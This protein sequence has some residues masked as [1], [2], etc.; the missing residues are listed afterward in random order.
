M[1][2]APAGDRT[3][4]IAL[5]TNH[6]PSRPKIL[7]TGDSIQHD[8]RGAMVWLSEDGVI[9]DGAGL[10]MVI[11]NCP[12]LTVTATQKIIIF[13]GRLYVALWV[14][15]RR[16]RKAQELPALATGCARSRVVAGAPSAPP[17]MAR[18]LGELPNL[19]ADASSVRAEHRRAG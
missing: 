11:R 1:L 7:K 14:N 4:T 10:P 2:A 16:A 3:Q 17:R 19:L 9:I 13:S 18:R 8:I 12:T 5:G 15:D 6:Q